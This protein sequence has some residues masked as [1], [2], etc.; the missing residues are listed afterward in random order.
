MPSPAT[1]EPP[2]K[3]PLLSFFSPRSSPGADGNVFVANTGPVQAP[4]QPPTVIVWKIKYK[5]SQ[6]ESKF[7]LLFLMSALPPCSRSHKFI[8]PLA[9]WAKA[10]Q[11]IPRV[12]EW[13]MGIIKR[14]YSSQGCPETK[15]CLRAQGAFHSIQSSGHHALRASSF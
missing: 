7:P 3:Q 12:S 5:H 9:M 6:K 2:T 8:Q 15:A 11:A 4:K 10:W 13:V 14:D 1:V